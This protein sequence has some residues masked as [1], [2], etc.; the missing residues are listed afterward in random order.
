[1]APILQLFWKEGLSTIDPPL[2]YF[3]RQL[4]ST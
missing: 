1:V 2:N 4:W 3:H